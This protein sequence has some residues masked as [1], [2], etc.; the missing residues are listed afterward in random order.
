[1]KGCPIRCLW[2]SNP[3]SQSHHE[4]VAFL[5][6]NCLLCG[7][8]AQICPLG[9][10]EPETYEIDRDIC[11]NCGKCAEI[12]PA[13][14]KKLIGRWYTI[15]ELIKKVEEDRIFYRNS[16][17][18]VTIS[19]GEP[20]L[21]YNF[22]SSFLK[23]CQRLNISTAIETCGYAKWEHLEAIVKFSDLVFFDIKHMDSEIHKTLTGRSNKLILQ[24]IK[25]ASSIAPVI[26]RIPIIPGYN[27]SRENIKDTV[28]FVQ[29]LKKF[30]K[31][32]LLPYH[33][34][35]AY[36][37]EWL[38]KL[39]ELN[40]LSFRAESD[41]PMLKEMV[42]SLGCKIEIMTNWYTEN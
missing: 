4:E 30:H 16:D 11:D 14:A 18:G 10:I 7:D 20:A 40:N 29:K 37:Y 3:E 42:N 26:I 19:G 9:A 25:K 34:L 38:G 23:E 15:D 32:E 22:V 33:S 27:D 31:I 39:Y 1:M 8:C 24:N 35:G 28:S 41:L 36:K 5:Q 2:C 17:G 21:Q 12:C 6:N 13:N